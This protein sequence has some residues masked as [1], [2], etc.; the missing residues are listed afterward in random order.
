MRNALTSIFSL[1]KKTKGLCIKE[2]DVIADLY[3]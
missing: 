3:N 1:G 2:G